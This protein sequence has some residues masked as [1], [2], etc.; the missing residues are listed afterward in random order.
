MTTQSNPQVWDPDSTY[1]INELINNRIKT[2]QQINLANFNALQFPQEGNFHYN[3]FKI[4]PKDFG[5]VLIDGKYNRAV[6]DFNYQ[7]LYQNIDRR[8]GFSYPSA[9]G[10]KI[11][12]RP[13]GNYYIVDGVHR[14]SF[15]AVKGIPIYGNIHVHDKTLSEEECRQHEA[16]VYTD[17]GYH[18]YSQNAEQNFKAAYVANE[19][20]A[21][22]FAKTLRKIGMH[23]KKIGQKNGPKLTGYKTFQ[24]TLNDYD[25]SYAVEAAGLMSDKMKGRVSINALFLSGLTTFLANQDILPKLND[26]IVKSAI[27]QGIGAK[28]FLKGTIHGKPTEG[29]AL[30][31]AHLYNN[32]G[33]GMRGFHA[34]DLGALCKHLGI[35]VAAIEADN[36]IQTV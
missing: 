2:N 14:S 29:I 30:R 9:S 12:Q 23:I 18:V 35:P 6:E 16:Q 19:T 4:E 25:V 36:Y 26:D 1:S 34:I 22:D 27:A 32:H 8:G 17:M 11:F 33:N 31:I 13:D 28:N 15:C 10:I 21:I 3:N 24:D 5:K 20:W 7:K